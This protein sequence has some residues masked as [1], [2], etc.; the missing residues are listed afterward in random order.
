M[1]LYFSVQATRTANKAFEHQEKAF[2][3]ENRP[4]IHIRPAKSEKVSYLQHKQYEDK[5]DFLI[6]FKI[7]NLGKTQATMITYPQSLI[8]LTLL[9]KKYEVNMNPPPGTPLSL[10]PGQEFFHQ[11]KTTVT[12]LTNDKVKVK[13]AIEALYTKEYPVTAEIIVNYRDNF[14]DNEYSVKARFKISKASSQIL[15]YES[16]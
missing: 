10:S 7:K 8:T 14:T 4:R 9:D 12:V 5:V 11:L 2:V 13:E 15:Q 6:Q 1:A 16:T 3:L